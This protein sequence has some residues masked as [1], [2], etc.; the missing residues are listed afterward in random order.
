MIRILLV[1]SVIATAVHAATVWYL[2]RFAMDTAMSRLEAAGGETNSWLHVPPTDETSRRVVRPSPDL[3][4]SVC[5]LDVSEGPVRVQAADWGDFTSLSL[6]ASNTDNI[7]ARNDRQTS[8]DIEIVVAD[9]ADG[10]VDLGGQTGIALIRRL[11]PDADR[12]A[13]AD[14]VRRARDVCEPV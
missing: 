10:E 8:G 4:Y 7:F 13:A 5:L 6:F 9:G 11:A 3:L 12:I 14:A 1:F 2:P